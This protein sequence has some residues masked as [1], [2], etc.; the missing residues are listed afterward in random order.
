MSFITPISFTLTGNQTYCL[1]GYRPLGSTGAFTMVTPYPTVSP[2]MLELPDGKWE[3]SVQPSCAETLGPS[4]SINATTLT[5]TCPF[6]SFISVYE[7]PGINGVPKKRVFKV[8]INV[9]VEAELIEWYINGAKVLESLSSTETFE[10]ADNT[11]SMANVT[12]GVRTRCNATSF[13][14]TKTYTLLF[15][16]PDPAAIVCPVPGITVSEITDT[17]FKV[18]FTQPE[19]ASGI[20][21]KFRIGYRVK[22]TS[23]YTYISELTVA[24]LPKLISGLE[25]EVT[26]EVIGITECTEGAT[27]VLSNPTAIKEVIT[28]A[29]GYTPEPEG[30][31]PPPFL[32]V[33]VMYGNKAAF[34]YDPVEG[35]T[36]YKIRIVKAADNT[37]HNYYLT[38][39][40]MPFLVHDLVADTDYVASIQSIAG[41]E[42]SAWGESVEFTTTNTG[43]GG[44]GGEL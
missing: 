31:Q 10:L 35:A 19:V 34:T 20:T 14:S 6:P 1:I 39:T 41:A 9:P 38:A 15:S 40:V 30:L 25:P 26:Y 44:G 28:L 8:S 12:V 42:E 11:W 4:K 37:L 7:M 23:T 16:Q 21:T 17:S 27:T 18:N 43:Q 36:D 22:G 29:A 13:S 32:L 33:D 3:V 24:E 2:Y 5:L